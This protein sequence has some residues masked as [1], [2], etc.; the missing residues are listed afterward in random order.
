MNIFMYIFITWKILFYLFITLS[1]LQPKR[2]DFLVR[3][4]NIEN[5]EF[6][7]GIENG[8]KVG[9]EQSLHQGFF[10]RQWSF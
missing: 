7:L 5:Q 1:I 3:R 6:A 9:L 4:W 8:T 2:L 10:S